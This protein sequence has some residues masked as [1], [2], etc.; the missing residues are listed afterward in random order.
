MIMARKCIRQR[1][2]RCI[3]KASEGRHGRDHQHTLGQ[4]DDQSG[5]GKTHHAAQID[6]PRPEETHQPTHD[7]REEG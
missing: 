1:L 4:T 3:G 2:Q 7:Q 5:Y 6:S